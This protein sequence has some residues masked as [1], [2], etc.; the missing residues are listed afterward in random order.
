MRYRN[1]F[2]HTAICSG[3]PREPTLRRVG[4]RVALFS[5][6][7]AGVWACRPGGGASSKSKAIH[8]PVRG[9]SVVVEPRAAEFFEGRVLSVNGE[10][11]RVEPLGGGE[12]LSVSR[13]DVYPLSGAPSALS[14]G[15]FAICRNSA[16]PSGCRVEQ[17]SNDRVHVTLL[18]QSKLS[19]APSSVL[20]PSASTELNL[21]QAFARNTARLEFERDAAR[22][23]LPVSPPGFLPA[24]HARVLVH[25]AGGWYSGVVHELR[26]KVAY[27][28]FAPDS[29]REQVPRS[30]LL[31]EPPY[32]TQPTRGDFVLVRPDSPAEPWRTLRVLG[33]SERDFR[34]G[35]PGNDERVVSIRDLVPLAGA[36]GAASR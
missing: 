34:V 4:V 14:P 24:L 27:V 15:Q 26:E 8:A 9:D 16:T 1:V 2:E 6:I 7:A 25:R 29:V 35:A 20:S 30:E 23:A 12:P 22:A 13:A 10:R 18:S 32:A 28:A 31:P 5:L 17:V 21:R 19:L 36:G 3:V 33:T 11:L